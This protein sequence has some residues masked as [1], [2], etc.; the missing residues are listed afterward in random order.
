MNESEI[1]TKKI[2]GEMS[3]LWIGGRKI[4]KN[5]QQEIDWQVNGIPLLEY[6]TEKKKIGEGTP[7]EIDWEA[8]EMAMKQS[9]T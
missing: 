3:P 4:V 2:Y 7:E 8:V 6:W 9:K 5:L 1:G